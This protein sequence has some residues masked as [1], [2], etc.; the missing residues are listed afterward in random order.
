[1]CFQFPVLWVKSSRD[2]KQ[3]EEEKI[4]EDDA[5]DW[6]KIDGEDHGFL[7]DSQLILN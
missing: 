1:M 5:Y 6:S 7:T 2:V 4:P 3:W